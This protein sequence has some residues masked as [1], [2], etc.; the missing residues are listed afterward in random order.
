MTTTDRKLHREAA[1]TSGKPAPHIP[2]RRTKAHII[3]DDAEAI[4]VAHELARVFAA[5]AAE[6]DRERRL[7]LAEI[8]RFSQS[9]LWAITVPKEFGGAGV[10]AVTLAEVTAIISAADGSIGQIPQNHF[11]MVEALRLAGSEE[12]KRHYFERVLDGDRL[13][14]AFTEI[15]TK[16]PVDYKTH[17][18]ERDGKLLLNGQKFYSTGSLFAHIIVVVAKG[19]DGRVNIVF[20]DR[21]TAGLSLIDDWTSF[22]QRT[23]GSG[24]VTFD[25]IEITPF[26]VVDHDVV[27]E[28]PTAMGP[29]AQ[30]IHAAVQV[31]IARGALAETI[32]YVRAHARPFFELSIEHGY[33]DPHTIHAVGDVSIRV[34]AADAL[35][36]RAGRILDAA[37]AAPD[38]KTVAAA[39][40]AV[41]EVKSLGTE[42]AQLASTKL[43]ELGGA[44]STLESY[45]LD[46][47]WRNA[48]THSL[49]DPVRW[50][51]HHI[52]NFYLNG[53][54]PPR[55]GAI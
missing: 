9:G 21:A 3:K 36:A 11:Y 51:Y 15:G 19:P 26:Q 35:L 52:G 10:S 24:T 44:R 37:I 20:I 8:E 53:A 23:T 16:T 42:V 34:H 1:L 2:P 31:G 13:G 5:G 47:Y 25:D 12:Q 27:F 48:R 41:A 30:I 22:G 55:H 7:P 45:G 46:R 28:R 40:I 29:F 38:E 43:I 49:H 17:F 14:N 50:K 33:E 39:S 4:A 32:S 6:R 54:L 18:A